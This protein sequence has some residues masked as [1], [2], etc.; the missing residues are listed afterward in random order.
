MPAFDLNEFKRECVLA[1]LNHAARFD[2]KVVDPGIEHASDLGRGGTEIDGDVSGGGI[3]GILA[4]KLLHFV[5]LW[6]F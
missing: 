2:A 4:N 6:A 3:V 1:F 5:L